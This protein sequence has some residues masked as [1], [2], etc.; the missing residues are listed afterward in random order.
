M[1]TGMG[2]RGSTGAQRRAG[3]GAGRTAGWVLAVCG[4]AATGCGP[5]ISLDEH[6]PQASSSGTTSGS[7][8]S[9]HAPTDGSG[10]SSE[11]AEPDVPRDDLPPPPLPGECPPGCTVELPLA[12]ATE[13]EVR[14]GDEQPL[15]RQLST[16][17]ELDDGGWV[18]A[19]R[20][21]GSPWLTRVSPDGII[22][23]S[24]EA[25]LAV[26]GYEIVDLALYPSGRLAVLGQGRERLY[27]YFVLGRFDLEA[28][29]FEWIVSQPIYGSEVVAPRV[30]AVI[31]TDELHAAVVVVEAHQLARRTHEELIELFVF[32]DQYFWDYRFIYS[33]LVGVGTGG[34][35]RGE[36]LSDGELAITF[37][38]SS[39]QGGYAAWLDAVDLTPYT[40]ETLPAAPEATALGPADELVV[41]GQD[42]V[43]EEQVV[44]SA[45]GL[46]PGQSPRWSLSTGV[47]TT[48]VGATAL[49]VDE[50]GSAVLA[51]RTTGGTP[52]DPG[53]PE[54]FVTRLAPDGTSVWSTTLPLA[55]QGSARPLALDL[56]ADDAIVLAGIVDGHLHVERREQ[57]C[58]CD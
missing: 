58:R 33:Q 46:R 28:Q 45:V 47:R 32:E 48:S 35:P 20:R 9:T 21:D 6:E 49:A 17:V 25:D 8:S 27:H 4:L 19:D 15:E 53:D 42:V 14:R 41:A 37:V 36:R 55:V 11:G 12:W 5:T 3:D 7:G 1:I 51:L 57:G 40:A 38:D 2:E 29:L 43:T 30:G 16:M 23:W 26:I 50:L 31:P 56:T 13:D 22:E 39:G 24:R 10:S 18:V 54:V 52:G 34:R 44:L